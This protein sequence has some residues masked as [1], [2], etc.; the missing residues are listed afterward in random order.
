MTSVISTS[1]IQYAEQFSGQQHQLLD[2]IQEATEK[3]LQYA[4]ML[5]GYQVTG[6]LQL[7]VRLIPAQSMLEV[8]TFTGFATIAMAQAAED[9]D[10]AKVITLDMN[11]RYADIAQRYFSQYTGST[12][13]EQRMGVA[14]DTIAEMDEHEQYQLMFIDADKANYP[15]YF[16]TLFSRLSPGGCMV[17]DNAFWGG[18][19]LETKTRKSK[20]IHRLNEKV[21]EH[22]QT[23]N[24]LLTVRD[25]LHI[26]RKKAK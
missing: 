16:D 1:L 7:L 9:L 26:V 6:I 2:A 11:T 20:A 23:E 3:E 5:S 18:E 22:P 24:V 25:G 4:D 19:V 15:T 12:R 10:H 8:G 14:L 13:I 17:F 21:K